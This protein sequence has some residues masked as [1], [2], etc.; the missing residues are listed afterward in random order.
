MS[1]TYFFKPLT[2]NQFVEEFLNIRDTS[3]PLSDRDRVKPSI[4]EVTPFRVTCI[5]RT[6]EA[7]FGRRG[8]RQLQPVVW[9]TLVPCLADVRRGIGGEVSGSAA[10]GCTAD[11]EGGERL[12]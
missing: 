1:A 11:G 12:E 2:V 6:N 10:V 9:A 7:S 4:A 8:G 3:R 5:C